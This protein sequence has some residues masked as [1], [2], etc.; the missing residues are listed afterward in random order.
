MHALSKPK[1]NTPPAALGVPPAQYCS[2]GPPPAQRPLYVC[3]PPIRTASL[4]FFLDSLDLL[5]NSIST[6]ASVLLPLFA[7]Q[8]RKLPAC[9][10]PPKNRA[11]PSLAWSSR[12]QLIIDHQ[13]PPLLRPQ[14]VS[15]RPHQRF[16]WNRWCLQQC[17]RQHQALRS[18]QPSSE[19]AC[20]PYSV[21]RENE[22]LR[23]V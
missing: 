11:C 13:N 7:V 2:R 6:I 8:C 22:M 5:S 19:P 20:R 3:A 17:E 12:T 16:Q 18:P 23:L 15:Q 4:S 14:H 9:T 21:P 1:G 10:Q